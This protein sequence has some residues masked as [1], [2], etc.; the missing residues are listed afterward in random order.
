MGKNKER[1]QQQQIVIPNTQ[2]ETG[3]NIDEYENFNEH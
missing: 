1:I 2:Q 3:R